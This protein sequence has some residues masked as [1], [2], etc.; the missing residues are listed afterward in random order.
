M[1]LPAGAAQQAAEQ[2]HFAYN[3]ARDVHRWEGAQAARSP[4]CLPRSF[5][6]Q[7]KLLVV[8]AVHV[9]HDSPRT[10]GG[11]SAGAACTMVFSAVSK[12]RA[13]EPAAMAL[14]A[15]MR[16]SV[17]RRE[18]RRRHGH[19]AARSLLA[20]LNAPPYRP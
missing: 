16:F 4:A 20:G 5:K 3:A 17:P 1:W 15:G 14:V 10:P 8:E 6:L 18:R 9:A 13:A 12:S 11:G 2:L 7:S 19:A